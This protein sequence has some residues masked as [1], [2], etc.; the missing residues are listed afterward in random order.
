MVRLTNSSIIAHA[1]TFVKGVGEKYSNFIFDK[2]SEITAAS[3][4]LKTLMF[5]GDIGPL[6]KTSGENN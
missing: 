1:H 2:I 5:N 6:T 3:Q 4:R